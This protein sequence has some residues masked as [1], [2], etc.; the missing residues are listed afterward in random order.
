MQHFDFTVKLVIGFSA[1]KMFISETVRDRLK[2]TDNNKN[3]FGNALFLCTCWKKRNITC[4]VHRPQC[5]LTS[6]MNLF[7][8]SIEFA[9]YIEKMN[10]FSKMI[11]SFFENDIFFLNSNALTLFLQK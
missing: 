11:N 4:L 7:I 8:L 10:N 6:Q 5:L 9:F 1:A 2:A 3:C